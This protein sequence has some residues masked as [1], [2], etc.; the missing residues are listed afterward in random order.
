VTLIFAVNVTGP[1]PLTNEI[2]D[3]GVGFYSND[4][5][6]RHGTFRSAVRPMR[7]DL[8][9]PEALEILGVRS[10]KELRERVDAWPDPYKVWSS[11][12]RTL[13]RFDAYYAPPPE[14]EHVTAKERA[15]AASAEQGL[16]GQGLVEV[17]SRTTFISA[18][19]LADFTYLAAALREYADGGPIWGAPRVTS[20]S[21]MT[22]DYA[23]ALGYIG[24]SKRPRPGFEDLL[25]FH[26]VKCKRV[27][28]TL[29]RTQAA[30]RA[31]TKHF[32][33]T[34]KIYAAAAKWHG[35]NR[36]R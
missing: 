10:H 23:T 31:I 30:A 9:T 24:V 2:I 34:E 25:H 1:D 18:H 32:I 36:Y 6:T 33:N 12:L 7:P 27:E 22:M 19:T 28:D 14:G 29:R 20:L 5:R 17:A 21:S 16:R 26:Q 4:L 35:A 8:A 3:L 13:L 11:F 15:L